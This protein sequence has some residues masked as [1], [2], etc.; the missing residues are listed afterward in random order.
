MFGMVFSRKF[1]QFFLLLDLPNM[2]YAQLQGLEKLMK[3]DLVVPE[4]AQYNPGL[5][6]I[7]EIKDIQAPYMNGIAQHLIKNRNGL[8]LLPDGTGRVYKVTLDGKNFKIVRQDST[9]FFG[10]N[11]GFFPFSYNDTL[12]SFGGYGFWRYNGHL[13]TFVSQK[14]EWELESLNREIPF[15]RVGYSA[16][17]KWVDLKNGKFWIGFSIDSREGIKKG[18]TDYKNVIDSVSVLDLN[19]KAWKTVGVL[20]SKSREIANTLVNRNLGSSPWGQ[21][22]HDPTKSV[23]Y[24]FDFTDNELLSLNADDTRSITRLLEPSSILFFKDSTLYVGL[25]S[26]SLDSV[27]LSKSKFVSTATPVY[28]VIG[29]SYF[30]PQTFSAVKIIFWIAV[31]ILGIVLS[32]F[33]YFKRRTFVSVNNSQPSLNG[34]PVKLFD[35]KE[36]EIVKLIVS[37]SAKG[38]GTSIEEINRSLGVLQ[39]NAEIQKKQRSETLISINRKWR[40]KNGSQQLLIKSRRIEQDKRSFEYFIDFENLE[41]VNHFIQ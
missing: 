19:R 11:F 33:F 3:P 22:I 35:D 6:T 21:L 4:V 23:I 24:L 16:S 9:L 12:Y 28:H 20:S 36:I 38:I 8:Y 1:F 27:S 10:Y 2:V 40:F 39:K 31:G 5:T 18:E 7:F 25:Q 15:T 30:Q 17:P 34:S 37:K 32:Y 26:R 14:G 13:R 29:D 41:I